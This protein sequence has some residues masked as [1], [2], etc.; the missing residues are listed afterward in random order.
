MSVERLQAPIQAYYEEIAAIDRPRTGISRLFGPILSR[1]ERVA[2]RTRVRERMRQTIASLHT[3]AAQRAAGQAGTFVD[4]NAL[5]ERIAAEWEA[6][7]GFLKDLP[8]MSEAAAKARAA[9]YMAAVHQTEQRFRVAMLPTL[10]VYPGDRRLAC[11]GF[12]K[13]HLQVER[14]GSADWDVYWRL[15]YEAEHCVDCINLSAEWNPL[16]IRN[17]DIVGWKALSEHDRAVLKQVRDAL[18]EHWA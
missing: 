10:P 15:N 5:R 1:L 6:L 2:A 4:L 13:C 3:E 12:C 7:D 9:L 18:L 16:R 17:G 11:E 14:I 8:N